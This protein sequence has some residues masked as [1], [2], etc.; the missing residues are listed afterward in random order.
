MTRTEER[1]NLLR[2]YNNKTLGQLDRLFTAAT[3]QNMILQT[4]PAANDRRHSHI[5][6]EQWSSYLQAA[7][8][9]LVDGQV[10]GDGGD[11]RGKPIGHGLVQKGKAAA[12]LVYVG[13]DGDGAQNSSSG[14]AWYLPPKHHR[15]HS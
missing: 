5:E 10:E 6:L 8:Y 12:G 14:M 7:R 13:V 9:R 15:L 2:R 3:L 1:R 4:K 11:N